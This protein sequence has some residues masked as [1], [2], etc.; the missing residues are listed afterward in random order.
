MSFNTLLHT[1][2]APPCSTLRS[3]QQKPRNGKG[4]TVGKRNGTSGCAECNVGD[5]TW[6]GCATSVF[7]FCLT[8]SDT[9]NFHALR[10]FMNPLK[11]VVLK[12]LATGARGSLNSNFYFKCSGL[13]SPLHWGS[14]GFSAGFRDAAR[15]K[16]LTFQLLLFCH[17]SKC[18]MWCRFSVKDIMLPKW[19]GT[20]HQD[21]ISQRNSCADT[22]S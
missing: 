20:S 16:I 14:S 7:H 17:E 11:W 3:A 13:N 6:G 18:H 4:R 1:T 10:C 8:K 15:G 21:H 22:W 9:T 2:A 19:C 5:F 12:Y